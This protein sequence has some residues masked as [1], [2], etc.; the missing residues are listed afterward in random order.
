MPKGK[1]E[2]NQQSTSSS[3]DDNQ[4]STPTF[5]KNWRHLTRS[6]Q[7]KSQLDFD[8]MVDDLEVEE[9]RPTKSRQD[10]H[11]VYLFSCYFM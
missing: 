4:P 10:K 6:C 9:D 5:R 3:E 8:N 2:G 1:T 7:I 11:R